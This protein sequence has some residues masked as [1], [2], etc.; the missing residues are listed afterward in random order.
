M[1]DIVS[2]ALSDGKNIER[3]LA[4]EG[5]LA[6]VTEG[7]S[8]RPLFKTHR[9][10]VVIRSASGEL[11][12]YDVAL[13]RVGEKYVFHRIVGVD[14]EKRVYLVRGDNTYRL[15]RVPFETVIGVL[16]SFNRKGKHGTVNDKG[17]RFYSRA[18]VALYPVRYAL[19]LPY[20]AARRLLRPIKRAFRKR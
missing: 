8:M 17:Y 19:R 4:T 14:R 6:S 15:E 3:I 7:V 1:S 12:R 11:S 2:S 20:V 13:Y 16:E 5:V 9:D 18:W 10:M